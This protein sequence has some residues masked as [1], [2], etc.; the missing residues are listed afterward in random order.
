MLRA[1]QPIQVKF[2]QSV[3]FLR[4][5]TVRRHFGG[6]NGTN[7][8]HI[9]PGINPRHIKRSGSVSGGVNPVPLITAPLRLISNGIRRH[10]PRCMQGFHAD[11]LNDDGE[12]GN[13]NIRR[14]RCVPAGNSL[15]GRWSII[16]PVS[17]RAYLSGSCT[18]S[19]RVNVPSLLSFMD[20]TRYCCA[21]S[22]SYSAIQTASFSGVSLSPVFDV[23][24]KP[25]IMP[26]VVDFYVTLHQRL[27]V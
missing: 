15:A 4:N 18:A 21:Y 6:V 11:I 5:M 24:R 12:R 25:G 10:I 1:N 8:H 9:T 19:V 14:R 27:T 17:M 26:L 22:V 7:A 13:A 3:Q 23:T 20:V 2:S 16:A